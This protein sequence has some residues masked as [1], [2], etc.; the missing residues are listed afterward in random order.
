MDIRQLKYFVAIAEE[1][2]ITGAAKRLHMAQP[3]LSRQLKKM[4][5][6]LGVT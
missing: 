5:E 1:K 6:E 4:E 3:P 2:T